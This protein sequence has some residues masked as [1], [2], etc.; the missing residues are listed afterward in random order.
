[1]SQAK[2]LQS[3][4]RLLRISEYDA[5]AIACDISCQKGL[6]PLFKY[7]FLN[8]AGLS[9][10]VN[11]AA[12]RG[13]SQSMVLLSHHIDMVNADQFRKGVRLIAVDRGAAW[14]LPGLEAPPSRVALSGTIPRAE[15]SRSLAFISP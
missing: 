7:N 12:S 11:R 13:S 10:R 4:A 1:M 3:M 6:A 14:R 8:S 5:I 2:A 15:P 9:L